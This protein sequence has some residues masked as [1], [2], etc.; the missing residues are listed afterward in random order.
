MP[1]KRHLTV[2]A[3][4]TGFSDQVQLP[5]LRLLRFLLGWEGQWLTDRQEGWAIQSA[6]DQAGVFWSLLIDYFVP[7][8]RGGLHSSRKFPTLEGYY[9]LVVGI[10]NS[11]WYIPHDGGFSLLTLS[12]EP[13]R[14]GIYNHAC[15]CASPTATYNHSQPP[16]SYQIWYPIIPNPQARYLHPIPSHPPSGWMND[17]SVWSLPSS[18][19]SLL[20]FTIPQPPE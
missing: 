8:N 6:Y 18:I 3:I 20:C 15:I 16:S 7:H 12:C 4:P 17:P 1:E 14:H 2:I 19:S 13:R 11:R 10:G 5:I 9:L